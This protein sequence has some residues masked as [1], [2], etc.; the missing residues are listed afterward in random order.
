MVASAM[1]SARQPR[2]NTNANGNSTTNPRGKKK[3]KQCKFG[4]K[5]KQL[6]CQFIRPEGWTA[7]ATDTDNTVTASERQDSNAGNSSDDLPSLAMMSDSAQRHF[8]ARIAALEQ[9]N[10]QLRSANEQLRSNNQQL[11]RQLD[12]VHLEHEAELRSANTSP[13]LQ[14]QLT[15]Q[16][17]QLQ[18]DHAQ[19]KLVLQQ[20]LQQCQQRNTALANQLQTEQT[21]HLQERQFLQQELQ[22]WKQS[23][24]NRVKEIQ[25]LQASHEQEKSAL[26][27]EVQ[28]W[29][30]REMAKAR[31]LED[32][33]ASK[34]ELNNSNHKHDAVT[35]AATHTNG[36]HHNNKLQQ[37]NDRSLGKHQHEGHAQARKPTQPSS[38]GANSTKCDSTN[39]AA[40]L[41]GQNRKQDNRKKKS[42]V[43]ELP[44]GER[45]GTEEKQAASALK[46]ATE[47]KKLKALEV[48][49]PGTGKSA[50]PMPG[51]VAKENENVSSQIVMETA[52]NKG[53]SDA[54]SSKEP[55]ATTAASDQ[56][57][58]GQP[59][60]SSSKQIVVS[61]LKDDNAVVDGP[62]QVVTK[63]NSLDAATTKTVSPDASVKNVGRSKT[64]AAVTASPTLS[65]VDD[66]SNNI[67][68]LELLFPK[69][70]KDKRAHPASVTDATVRK[71]IQAG[72]NETLVKFLASKYATMND[73]KAVEFID[74]ANKHLVNQRNNLHTMKKII[75]QEGRE[76]QAD[77]SREAIIKAHIRGTRDKEELDSQL[78]HLETLDLDAKMTV[79]ELSDDKVSFLVGRL[80]EIAEKPTSPIF[81]MIK[82]D[83]ASVCKGRKY[84]ELEKAIR[85]A[86]E[87]QQSLDKDHDS[88]VAGHRKELGKHQEAKANLESRL[89]DLRAELETIAKWKKF[90]K[91]AT[92]E[93]WFKTAVAALVGG[94]V[95]RKNDT[96]SEEETKLE[97][98]ADVKTDSD[99][100]NSK[101]QQKKS[102]KK[103]T[104]GDKHNEKEEFKPNR[105]RQKIYARKEGQDYASPEELEWLQEQ[106]EQEIR[107]KEK[108]LEEKNKKVEKEENALADL[109]TDPAIEKCRNAVQRLRNQLCELLGIEEEIPEDKIFSIDGLRDERG[110]SF[111]LVAVLCNDEATVK[112]CCE[113]GA[114]PNE[115]CSGQLSPMYVATYFNMKRLI[116]ILSDHGGL[117]SPS[118]PWANVGVSEDAMSTGDWESILEIATRVAE[119]ASPAE[120]GRSALLESD[121]KSRMPVLAETERLAQQMSFFDECLI[122]ANV[123]HIRRQILLEKSVYSW[124]LEA[125]EEN[126]S[127]LLDFLSALLPPQSRR[128][129]VLREF[130][131]HRR[132]VIGLPTQMQYEVLAV[133]L[134][135]NQA[136]LFTP[137]VTNAVEGYASVGVVVWAVCPEGSLSLYKS[138]IQDT[139]FLRNK[140][141]S[142]EIFPGHKPFVLELGKDMHLLD[143]HSTNIYTSSPS[144][145]FSVNVDAGE[146][147][148]LEDP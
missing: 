122:D 69:I 138:L 15:T 129:S 140:V 5:C 126:R 123:A 1:E 137:F 124:F 135:N 63:K 121:E 93:D 12:M 39:E 145:L 18:A 112:T 62:V 120:E 75:A 136:V 41:T 130:V 20:E 127:V 34:Q 29:K 84:L 132:A 72:H 107:E 131:C 61:N 58:A 70:K 23:D 66:N 14:Q 88:R 146:L 116:Q 31:Q 92:P 13:S 57:A 89:K 2:R 9:E 55:N 19:E 119:A 144:V 82:G 78:K 109:E 114:S 65:A 68:L 139:E 87:Q 104:K 95:G 30:Q 59:S 73:R 47:R 56:T 134:N 54:R 64:V 50:K 4:K 53:L 37:H 35:K 100:M 16:L 98:G 108:H 142:G 74:K 51:A 11:H 105:I 45:G 96:P 106:D 52:S 97:E 90:K 80:N 128:R 3:K 60:E 94:P 99:E 43:T 49:M 71:L 46:G 28:S 21:G 81:D 83:E 141:D 148:L 79:S 101:K 147:E 10:S 6:N 117:P 86:K 36:N 115:L 76:G 67:R 7:D 85:D 8:L 42:I 103:K 118:E 17:Q 40:R 44:P 111:L 110:H 26:Q 32:L 38:T 125:D 102:N 25:Q 133:A 27:Q 143:L 22:S 24:T 48:N 91:P 33:K 77:P 113:I